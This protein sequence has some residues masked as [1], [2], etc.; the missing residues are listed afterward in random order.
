MDEINLENA[1]ELV[2]TAIQ[3]KL[4][5]SVPQFVLRAATA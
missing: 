3:G 4:G 1:V 2:L 5:I